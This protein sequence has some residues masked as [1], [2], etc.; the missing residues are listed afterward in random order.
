MPPINLDVTLATV[1]LISN[2]DEDA[3]RSRAR[4]E[5]A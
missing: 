4:L 2:E 1:S 5:H 3:G